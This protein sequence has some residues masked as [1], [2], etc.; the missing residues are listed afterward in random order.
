[1]CKI[2]VYPTL[3]KGQVICPSTTTTFLAMMQ[4]EDV[5]FVFPLAGRQH[6]GYGEAHRFSDTLASH[7]HRHRCV[8]LATGLYDILTSCPLAERATGHIEV[9]YSDGISSDAA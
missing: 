3:P 9:K 2:T 4:S 5:L 8:W 7:L 1:M 6:Q